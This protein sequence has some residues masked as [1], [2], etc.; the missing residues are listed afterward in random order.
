MH[1]DPLHHIQQQLNLLQASSH[2]KDIQHQTDLATITSS[3]SQIT[4]LLAGLLPA[5]TATL[6]NDSLTGEAMV[7]D[8]ESPLP[9]TSS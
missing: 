9:A 6:H 4:Q 8:K 1:A 3:I 2:A 7:T 5:T